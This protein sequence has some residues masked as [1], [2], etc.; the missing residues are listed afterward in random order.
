MPGT[1]RLIDISPRITEAT[2]VFPGDTP[3]QR[4]ILQ[5]L[6]RGD[7][8]TLSTLH[9]TVHVGAHADGPNHY[10]LGG[11]SIDEQPLDLYVGPC[12]LIR[13]NTAQGDLV[14]LEHFED[15][16]Q[17]TK[18]LLICTNSFPDSERWTS[19]FCGLDPALVDYLGDSGIGLVGIDTPSVDPADSKAL[20]AHQRFFANDMAILEGLILRDVD[21]GMYELIAPPLPLAGFDG[22]PVRAI[23]RT[24]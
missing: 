6:K 14:K 20:P 3:P 12:Q 15:E 23:L 10:G 2:V 22:S 4:E 11:R 21:P 17:K 1:S 18:R 5:E 8:V 24:L 19:D 7:V 9:S 13:T 16:L